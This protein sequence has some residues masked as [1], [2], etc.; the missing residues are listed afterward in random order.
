M[1][2]KQGEFYNLLHMLRKGYQEGQHTYGPCCGDKCNNM[3]RGSGL[4]PTCCEKR[5]AKLVGND[6]AHR[7]HFVTR[8][9]AETVYKCDQI[10]GDS[11][12]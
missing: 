1:N 6:L 9:T 3:A 2:E 12:E 8:L 11:D 7:I 4:C 5:V 10:L